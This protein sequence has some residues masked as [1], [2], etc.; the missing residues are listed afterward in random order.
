MPFSSNNV[1]SPVSPDNLAPVPS[2]A[3]VNRNVRAL[4]DRAERAHFYGTITI[5]YENGYAV[6]V[7]REESIL[8]SRISVNG[9]STG[10]SD[11]R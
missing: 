3:A 10:G 4:L 5:R 7:R 8:P 11:V 1:S 9:T 2:D 6:H